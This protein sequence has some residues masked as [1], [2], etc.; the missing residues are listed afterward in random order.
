MG[1]RIRPYEGI[2]E[3]NGKKVAS[4]F[5]ELGL[6]AR[7]LGMTIVDREHPSR[8]IGVDWGKASRNETAQNA[9]KLRQQIATHE[10]M[11]WHKW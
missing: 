2:F 11:P 8:V 1:W 6:A 4:G 5:E 7:E 10:G 9:E 3:T